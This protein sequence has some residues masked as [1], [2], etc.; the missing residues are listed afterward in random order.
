M[1]SLSYTEFSHL[2]ES[3]SEPFILSQ[4][5]PVAD[6]NSL[7]NKYIIRFLFS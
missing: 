2:L 7:Y 3:V 4:F 1:P 6:V 5:I